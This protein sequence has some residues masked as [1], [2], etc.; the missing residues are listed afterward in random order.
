M[1]R[2]LNSSCKLCRREGMK[3][4]L[5]G[6]RCETGKCPIE[7]RQRNVAPGMHGWRRSRGSDYGVRLR[8]KQKVKRYYGLGETQFMR[9]VEKAEHTIGNTGEVLLG[10]LERRL[11]N[12]VYKLNFAPSRKSARQLIAHGH[13]RVNGKKVDIADYSVSIGDKITLK[14]SEKSK[15]R[16]RTQL[17]TNPNYSAQSWLQLDI[18]EPSATIVAMPS[19]QDVQLPIEEHLVI[20]FCSR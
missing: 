9:Y 13:I 17:D 4:M 10:M 16:I 5:K 2:Y 20:E 12:V 15:K 14:A 3:L 18:K 1:G 6:I 11:D 8:E 19:R 7:K